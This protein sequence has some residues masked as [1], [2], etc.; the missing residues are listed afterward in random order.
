MAIPSILAHTIFVPFLLLISLIE[1]W[2]C[3]KI[4]NNNAEKEKKKSTIRILL[5]LPTG[6]LLR[7]DLRHEKDLLSVQVLYYVTMPSLDYLSQCHFPQENG[8]EVYSNEDQ[9]PYTRIASR[10]SIRRILL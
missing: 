5:Y 9:I 4:N 3:T 7:D 6:L 2:C 10:Y 8:F 1:R